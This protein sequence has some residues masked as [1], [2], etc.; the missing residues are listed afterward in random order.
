MNHM[1][2]LESHEFSFLTYIIPPIHLSWVHWIKCE[3][4]ESQIH[5]LES[6]K[7]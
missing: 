3:G 2:P 1:I 7:K 5:K 6:Q 4:F